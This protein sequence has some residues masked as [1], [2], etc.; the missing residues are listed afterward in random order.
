MPQLLT[1]NLSVTEKKRL[2][3]DFVENEGIY[4]RIREQLLKQY[5]GQWV[6]LHDARVVASG[7]DLF[8]VT[9]EVGKLGCHAYIARVGEEDNLVFTIR[10]REFTYDVTYQ[11][12]ALPK[13]EAIFSNCYGTARQLC[14]DVIPDTG[15]DLSALPENDCSVIDLF[16]SPYLMGLTRGVFGPSVTTLVY[17]GNVEVNG[18]RYR[19]LIQPIPDGK[20]R[21]L[22]RDVL[23]QLKVTFDGPQ[24]KAIF[25]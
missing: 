2:H 8:D 9:D 14:P 25:D 11:P 17:R 6:A 18:T 21:M 24:K 7:N 23:N 3:K 5:A 1:Q 4:W 22:G 13:V 15:A 16:A 20:E 19:S 12:F 10:R